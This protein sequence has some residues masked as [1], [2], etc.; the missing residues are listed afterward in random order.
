MVEGRPG[1]FAASFLALSW[2][3]GSRSFSSVVVRLTSCV[4][5]GVGLVIKGLFSRV[6]VRVSEVSLYVK[7]INSA[8]LQPDIMLDW[9][10]LPHDLSVW[11]L[12]G[13]R[14]HL[15]SLCSAA[16]GSDG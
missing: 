2:L 6:G 1:L 14:I 10:T 16:S 15:T 9:H 4:W 12:Y 11:H 7:N 3:W 13:A 5:I 8:S